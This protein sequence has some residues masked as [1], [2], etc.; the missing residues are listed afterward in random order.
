MHNQQQQSNV[1]RFQP[2]GF[3]SSSYNQNP[4]QNQN[5][6]Q[7]PNP[8]QSNFG[9]HMNPQSF[10]SASYRGNQ[11]GHDSYLRADSTSPSQ[12]Q[13]GSSSEQNNFRPNFNS[14]TTSFQNNPSQ[15][16][17]PSQQSQ[18]S[19]QYPQYPQYPQ[20]QPSQQSFH[21]AAYRGD[22]QGHDSYLRADSTTPSQ[23]GGNQNQNQNF[24]S[25]MP[26]NTFATMQ[27]PNQIHLQSP[28]SFHTAAYRGDQQGHD[29]YLRADSTIPSQNQGGTSFGMMNH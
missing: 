4:N 20:S 5:Q 15:F 7:Y 16:Q 3:V 6:N 11:Q 26:M 22:Q 14:N 25:N 9:G 12:S 28:Q 21:T 24:S 17:Q 8:N 27:N 1:Q 13:F 23:S 18:Q 10:H 2:T 19:Q 29:S